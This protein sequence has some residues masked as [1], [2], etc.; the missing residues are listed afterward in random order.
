MYSADSWRD[1]QEPMQY[2][3]NKYCVPKNKKA[4]AMGCSFGAALLSNLMGHEGESCIL[5]AATLVNP[6]MKI[7]I[8][9]DSI[10]TSM[11]GGYNSGLGKNL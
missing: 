9:G 5:Q 10:N 8:C 6:P 2:I 3:Y 7:W 11:Y 1:L 4:F